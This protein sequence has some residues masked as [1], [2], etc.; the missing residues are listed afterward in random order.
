MYNNNIEIADSHAIVL[1]TNQ[2]CPVRPQA[3]TVQ[4]EHISSYMQVYFSTENQHEFYQ[5]VPLISILK[6]E[7]ELLHL[8]RGNLFLFFFAF[9]FVSLG[10]RHFA[11]DPLLG[12]Q[13]REK[14]GIFSQHVFIADDGN[15][16]YES[17]ACS[18]SMLAIVFDGVRSYHTCTSSSQKGEIVFLYRITNK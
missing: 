5:F 11:W 18:F 7:I 17:E 13:I 1:E 16:L 15:Y 2:M 12:H 14:K 6:M 9:F 10:E 8:L 3:L 4:P